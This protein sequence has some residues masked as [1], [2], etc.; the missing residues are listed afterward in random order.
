MELSELISSGHEIVIVD[1]REPYEQ[2]IC[3]I[4]NS[5]FIHMNRIIGNP[6]LLSKD[7]MTVIYCHHGIRSFILI[8]QLEYGYGFENLYNLDGGINRWA[9]QVD[10]YMECY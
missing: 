4:P 6:E 5:V 2:L 3:A 8:Q 9:E 10:N 7:I 1:I